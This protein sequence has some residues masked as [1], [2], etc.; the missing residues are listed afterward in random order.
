MGTQR[1]RLQTTIT[2][3]MAPG[4][5]LVASRNYFREGKRP[6]TKWY[7]GNYLREG[8]RSHVKL[9]HHVASD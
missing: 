3:T 6:Q 8:K 2:A 9:W 1:K 4:V 5:F 7:S